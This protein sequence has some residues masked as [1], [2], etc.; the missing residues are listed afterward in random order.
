M[1]L[2]NQTLSHLPIAVKRPSYDRSQLTTGIVHLGIGNFHRA[3]QAVYTDDVLATPDGPLDWGI[4]GVSLRKPAMRD[5]LAPQDGLY[6]L[7]QRDSDGASVRVVGSIQQLLVAPEAPETV[8]RTMVDPGVCIVSLTVTEKGYCH[9]PATGKLDETHPAIVADLTTPQQPSSAIGFLVEALDRRRHAGLPPFTV[10]SCDNLPN[11]GDT[12]RGLVLRFAEMRDQAL[13]DWISDHGAFPNSMVDRIVPATTQTDRDEAARILGL[14]DAWPVSTEPF[15]QWV[16]EDR[17]TDGRPAWERAGAQLVADVAPFELMK[18]RLLNGSHSTLAYLG[19][20]AGHETVADAMADISFA[21]L[22]R[23]LMATE[24]APTVPPPPNTDMAAY[25]QALCDRFANTALHHK[26]RQI[27]MDGS[28]K[29]PQRLL[30]AARDRLANRQQ[31]PLIALGVAGWCRYV[32]GV[33][34]KGRPIEVDDPLANR[35]RAAS[36]SAADPAGKVKALLNVSEVFGTD[37]ATSDPFVTAVTKAY[38]S[39]VSVGSQATV[40]AW[41]AEDRS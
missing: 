37:L 4:T 15:S 36:D 38:A 33:D 35:L 20:L 9:D 18:L 32:G 12:A 13:K 39:L 24:L 28:Q 3:H 7:I 8:L 29:L 25:Q 41:T 2:N 17:F 5:A 22:I 21:T 16:I 30:A 23:R 27:A 31:L 1:R 34:E 26:T 6:S 10:L 40:T 11:N 14:E 19:V